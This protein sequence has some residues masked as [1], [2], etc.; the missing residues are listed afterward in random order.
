[1]NGENSCFSIPKDE[2]RVSEA[3]HCRDVTDFDG[4]GFHSV[5]G[6]EGCTFSDNEALRSYLW[7]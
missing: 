3:R 4:P 2:A 6:C 5:G 1:M 7:G